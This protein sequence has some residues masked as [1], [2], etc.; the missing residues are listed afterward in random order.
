MPRIRISKDINAY[1]G[2]AASSHNIPAAEAS[3]LFKSRPASDSI[4]LF[5]LDP[6]DVALGPFSL[7]PTDEA[8]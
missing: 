8:L 6:S 2:D 7:V 4:R 3:G 5:K 1:K